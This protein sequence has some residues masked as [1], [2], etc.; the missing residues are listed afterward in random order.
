MCN[1]ETSEKINENIDNVKDNKIENNREIKVLKENQNSNYQNIINTNVK[2]K[3]ENK[4]YVKDQN[5]ISSS[6]DKK[7]N[8]KMYNEC[9]TKEKHQENKLEDIKNIMKS[10]CSGNI[11]F[12]NNCSINY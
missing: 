12:S 7:S 2:I 5:K 6:F 3:K 10:F 11:N 4:Y 9:I 8:K 1:L